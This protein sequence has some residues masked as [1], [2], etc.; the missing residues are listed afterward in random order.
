MNLWSDSEA[1]ARQAAKVES[2]GEAVLLTLLWWRRAGWTVRAQEPIDRFRIDLF[3]PEAGIAI[4]VDSFEAHGSAAL[5]ERDA[6]KRNLI[7]ARGWAPLSIPAQDALYRPHHERVLP[8]IMSVIGSRL[9]PARP[10]LKTS[11]PM[12]EED[13][14]GGAVMS[15]KELAE[16]G[17]AFLAELAS[18][19]DGLV[20]R[21]TQRRRGGPKGGA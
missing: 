14:A 12:P 1:Y 9:P 18:A 21:P 17:A 15:H 11:A 19:Q 3:I 10:R 6:T 13:H 5:M 2:A 20:P 16:R 7:V 4:E 8:R